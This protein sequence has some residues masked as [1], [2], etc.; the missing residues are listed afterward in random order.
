M[1][2]SLTP[3]VVAAFVLV[4]LA[5]VPALARGKDAPQEFT[6]ESALLA[7]VPEI[8]AALDAANANP[9][10]IAAWRAL[11]TVLS[12]RGAH[13]DAI[14]ALDIALELNDQD[15]DSWVDLGAAYVRAGDHGKAISALDEALDIEPFSAL[16][17]YN[18]GLAYQAKK[19]YDDA[20]DAFRSALLL[21]PALGDPTLNPGVVN[22]PIMPYVRL[23]VYLETAGAVP[24]VFSDTDPAKMTP[25][26][27]SSRR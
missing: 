5:V 16:A 14:R 11:G 24:A 1:R 26:A 2:R 19:D 7:N 12:R 20:F 23:Q 27:G 6:L 3:L 21:E 9:T 10:D 17:H 22:N 8:S 13:E 25:P 15:P 4:S 18:K